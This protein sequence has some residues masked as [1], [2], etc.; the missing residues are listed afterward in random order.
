MKRL[1]IILILVS[2]LSILPL[3]TH[4]VEKIRVGVYQ[5]EPLIFI[6]ND[7]EPKGIWI[8]ILEHI[9]LSE[10]WQIEYVPGSWPE[11]LAR[12]KTGDIDLLPNV[13]YSKNR[14]KEY[15]FS[16]EPLLYNWLEVFVQP[17]SDIKSVIDLNG[18]K[19]AVFKGS[20]SQTL[21]EEM[22]DGFGI[23]PVVL[24]ATNYAEV[25][26]SVENKSADAGIINH[27]F[28]MVNHF[29]YKVVKTNIFFGSFQSH[30]AS[31]KNGREKLLGSID[32]HLVALKA[33]NNSFYFQALDKWFGGFSDEQTVPVG[34]E[35]TLV[36]LAGVAALFMVFIVVMRRRIKA[37][38]SELSDINR[39][40]RKEIAEHKL[41]VEALEYARAFSENLIET[42]NVIFV[43]LDNAGNV[44]RINKRAEGI[45][46]YSLADLQGRNWFEVLVPRDRYP[47]V[48]E[49]F[50]RLSRNGETPEIFENPILTKSG[51]ERRII[52]ENKVLRK[53]GRIEGTISFG[54]DI[55]ERKQA[56]EALCDSEKRMRNLF[57]QAGDGIFLLTPD[58]KYLDANA[59]GLRMLGYSREELLGLR[60]SD[61]LAEH[62]RH[63]L[64]TE[65]PTM[66]AGTPHLAEWL[67]R[68]K[69]GTTFP[70]EVSA[71]AHS[72]DQYIAI[73]RDLTP[74][75]LAEEELKKYQAHLEE[76]VKARTA[77]LETKIAEIERMNRIFVGRELKMAE[78][79]EKIKNL[80]SRIQDPS[81]R[82][83]G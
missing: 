25:F 64:D 24:E 46:E 65:V 81:R 39:E 42:A 34:I 74:R 58:H 63:R 12:L 53:G 36:S 57:E 6:E 68:R 54:M 83:D 16:R 4:A 14:D 3:S 5:I 76:L 56:E 18:K 21:F 38:T 13:A 15:D 19:V 35:I 37:K 45:T 55:T 75:K 8:D 22:A 2:Q 80:E 41:T 26:N 66:M 60:I 43:Q 40:L 1:F 82:V 79:K 48:W 31:P 32:R 27:L 67:H 44:V 71:R 73:V 78:L 30:F 7:L 52:W 29:D 23:E 62:E 20:Y 77:E 72:N 50:V 59:E 28:G 33:D 49:E 10:K 51:G 61:V 69:D 9:A 11:C 17:K 47:H 70:A